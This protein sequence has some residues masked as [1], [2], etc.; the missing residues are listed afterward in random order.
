[1][2]QT[3]FTG[4]VRRDALCMICEDDVLVHYTNGQADGRTLCQ[5]DQIEAEAQFIERRIRDGATE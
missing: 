4:W 3:N 5:C 1:M 2:T